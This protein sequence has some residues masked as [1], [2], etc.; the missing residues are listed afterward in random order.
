M[1]AFSTSRS[2]Q[3]LPENSLK[4]AHPMSAMNHSPS[5]TMLWKETNVSQSGG[6]SSSGNSSMPRTRSPTLPK[7]MYE[8]SP[9]T[10]TLALMRGGGEKGIPKR[11]SGAAVWLV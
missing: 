6:R 5:T 7:A 2:S 10:S 9:G 1:S 8:S 4:A 11:T 3:S